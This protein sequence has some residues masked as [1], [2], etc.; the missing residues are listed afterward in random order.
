MNDLI[1]GNR[2]VGLKISARVGGLWGSDGYGASKKMSNV[3]QCGSCVH[4]LYIPHPAFLANC[5][6]ILMN[7]GRERMR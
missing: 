5:E 6:S 3:N 7:K 2:Y 4:N 1:K